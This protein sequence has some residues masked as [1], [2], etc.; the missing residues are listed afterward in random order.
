MNY[1]DT[2]WEK[3][4][5]ISE[6]NAFAKTALN[7]MMSENKKTIL[8]LG[9][10]NGADALYFYHNGL[11]VTG[12]DAAE[13]TIDTLRKNHP[14]IAWHCQDI[15]DPLDN[16]YEAI[17]AHCSLHYFDDSTTKII[18]NKIHTTLEAEGL[19][20]V[21]CKSTLDPLFGKGKHLDGNRYHFD[22]TRNFF[23]TDAMIDFLNDFTILSIKETAHIYHNQRSCFIEAIA[24]RKMQ[25]ESS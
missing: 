24:R 2:I 15:Q 10:G 12:I 14:R 1:W 6:P 13:K 11:S 22:H 18:F 4:N 21:K 5:N 9:C 8:D 25:H 20:I 3:Q 7:Y 23:T 19:L 16:K 17:Y